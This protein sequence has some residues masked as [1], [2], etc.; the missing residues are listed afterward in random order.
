MT[1][2]CGAEGFVVTGL[3]WLRCDCVVVSCKT[4]SVTL[5]TAEHDERHRRIHH[6]HVCGALA[7]HAAVAD[8]T[9]TYCAPC[10]RAGNG[11]TGQPGPAEP[12]LGP[13]ESA[14]VDVDVDA[15]GS[16]A[17]KGD[18]PPLCY[19]CASTRCYCKLMEENGG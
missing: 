1:C 11:Q 9:P 14:R 12:E 5:S 15:P 6:C 4:C 3:W 18:C 10:V 7:I 8:G 19:T 2:D 17:P 16:H 13:S